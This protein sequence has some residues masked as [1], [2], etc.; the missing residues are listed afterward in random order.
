MVTIFTTW[1]DIKNLCILPTHCMYV[2]GIVL[3]TNNDD[4]RTK[5]SFVFLKE[6][7]FVHCGA[8]TEL[9]GPITWSR[10]RWPRSLRCGYAA[11]RFLG[12][13]VRI[14][15]WAC[16]S[17]CCECCVLSGTGLCVGQV[18]H[19]EESTGC[20]VSECDREASISS[21]P[22]GAVAPWKKLITDK[23]KIICLVLFWFFPL[24]YVEYKVQ[25][26]LN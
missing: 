21:A 19:Q 25:A 2:F 22:L 13:R 23:I 26:F 9:Y 14:P 1:P 24:C 18:S 20:G 3:E 12:L 10:S 8:G 6:T 5:H 15:P 4:F 16:L 7:L 17:V 11:F